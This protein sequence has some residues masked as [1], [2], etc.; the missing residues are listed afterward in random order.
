MPSS[1]QVPTSVAPKSRRANSIVVFL[2]FLALVTLIPSFLFSGLLLKRTDEAQLEIVRSLTRA[3]THSISEAVDR[4]VDGLITTLKVLSTSTS[5]ENGN[6]ETFHNRTQEALE[7][8]GSFLL[9]LDAS[10][11]QLVNTRLPYG[12]ALPKSGDLTTP[13]QVLQSGETTVSDLF[14]G[15]VARQLVFDVLMPHVTN[16]GERQVLMLGQNAANLTQ[17]LTSTKLPQGWNA[18]LVDSKHTLAASTDPNLV[19]G[20]QFFLKL[21]PGS[22]FAPDWLRQRA[23]DTQYE[24]VV[25]RSPLTGWQVVAWAPSDVVAQPLLE[26]MIWLVGGW[27]VMTAG[28]VLS[29]FW[30]SGQ[31]TRSVKGLMRDARR[32]GRGDIVLARPYPVQELA[33]VSAE[34]ASAAETRRSAETEIRFLMREL[35]HRA[36]NQLSVINAMAK[37]TARTAVSLD[38]F[39]NDFQKRIMGLA[40][41]TDLLL[42][43]GSS[44]VTLSDLVAAHL[45]PF[46]P[47][48]PD[49]LSLSGPHLRV[50][51]E[52]AQS[53]GMAL[54]ELA[55]NAA[56]YGAFSADQGRLDV[57]WRWQGD[58][59]KLVWR[60]SGVEMARGPERRGFGSTVIEKMIVSTLGAGVEKSLHGDGIEWRFSF[61]SANL[62]VQPGMVNDAAT[63]PSAPNVSDSTGQTR[64]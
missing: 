25:Q 53:L 16:D 12:S 56:K 31:I 9:L 8:S 49:R 29:L 22:Q 63:R 26:S 15:A 64:S 39:L 50:Q 17:A 47:R 5:L 10:G 23:R 35:A 52:A 30:V 62:L 60:E 3:T 38:V 57:S 40:K 13:Q 19:P 14:M 21:P 28:V 20:Q 34:I 48:N 58:M 36:K 43:H 37:Q 2:V 1:K 55:T 51:A 44:G 46:Q 33:E 18:A 4:E 59:L 32:L 27:L 54:H 6:L 42:D 24:L 45:E 11:Q 41:S 7:D 61:P